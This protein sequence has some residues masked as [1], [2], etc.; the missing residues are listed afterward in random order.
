MMRVIRKNAW[1]FTAILV[2]VAIALAVG[3]YILDEQRLRFPLAE[4]KPFRINVE[5]DNA[6]A[7]TPGQGQTA[8][9]A[10]VRIGDIAQVSLRDG[11]AL[12][13]LDIEPRYADLIHRDARAQLRPRTGG[14]SLPGKICTYMSF[15]PVRGRSCARASRW[16]RSA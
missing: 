13:G 8:Q 11:R 15:S 7:V 9:V 4:P 16:M 2:L 10:G 6:Q 1:P 3:A 12:V 5:I 14:P